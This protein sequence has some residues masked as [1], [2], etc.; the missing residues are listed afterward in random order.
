MIQ[1]FC[2]VVILHGIFGHKGNWID[3]A[4]EIAE[5]TIRKVYV[6]DMRN[7]GDSPKS[8]VMSHDANVQDLEKFLRKLNTPCVLIGHSL[9]GVAAI[10]LAFQ[11]SNLIKDLILID[12]SPLRYPQNTVH[13]IL[14]G[15]RTLEELLLQLPTDIELVEAQNML[16]KEMNKLITYSSLNKIVCSNL[17]KSESGWKWKANLE[18][19]ETVDFKAMGSVFPLRGIYKGRCLLVHSDSSGYVIPEEDYDRLKTQFPKINIV[20]LEN[21]SHWIH[22]E[23]P[24]ELTHSIVQHL[25]KN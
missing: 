1:P 20:C 8:P 7:H 13:L 25:N 17:D 19:L 6:L 3:I 12:M 18:V 23:K 24:D 2:P 21:C 10:K 5:K 15:R 9:G 4:K 14:K 11:K 22:M 16:E